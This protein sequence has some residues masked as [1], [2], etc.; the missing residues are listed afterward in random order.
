[1]RGKYDTKI[2]VLDECFN[3]VVTHPN[4][5]FNLHSRK[6]DS[7]KDEKME[8]VNM[9]KELNKKLNLY[10]YYEK[11]IIGLC[12][13]FI[14]YDKKYEL[15]SISTIMQIKDLDKKYMQINNYA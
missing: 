11:I 13:R 1:M 2:L 9:V 4:M 12:A 14:I 3:Y 5:T 8:F 6:L 7:T 15:T 10:Y